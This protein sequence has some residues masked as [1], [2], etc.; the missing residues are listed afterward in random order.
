MDDDQ[1]VEES[2]FIVD[3]VSSIVKES[4]EAVIGRNMYEHNRVSQWTSSVAEQC[5]GQLSKLGKPFK[6]IGEKPV[7]GLCS[8]C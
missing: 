3:E 4:L 1:T 8:I 2:A 6:Y 5:L 7:V